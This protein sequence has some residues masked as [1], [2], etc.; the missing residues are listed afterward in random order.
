VTVWLRQHNKAELDALARSMYQKGSPNYHRWLTRDQ[1]AARFAPTAQEASTVRDYL[2]ARGLKIASVDKSN[3]FVV[4]QGRVA[5][6][7]NAFHVQINRFKINGEVRHANLADPMMEGDAG[8]LV[9]SV[10]GLSNRVYVPHV[11]R[12]IDPNSGKPYKGVP[13]AAIG[14]NPNGLFF[15]GN[16]L[17]SAQTHTFKTRGGNPRATYT[18]NRFGSDIDSGVGNLPPCGYSPAEV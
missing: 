16:C 3:H 4:A 17:R 9:S 18:G 15:A 8:A 10:Q 12:P 6:V 14:G 13:L 2:S 7:Q 5:D 11:A 1:Y